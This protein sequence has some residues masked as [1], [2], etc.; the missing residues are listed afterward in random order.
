[1]IS[2]RCMTR[3]EYELITLTMVTLLSANRY[4]RYVW[5]GPGHI[6]SERG[7]PKEP[8]IAVDAALQHYKLSDSSCRESGASSI[9]R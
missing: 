5:A 9:S 1:M 8:A 3:V 6:K 4:I 2:S 7:G